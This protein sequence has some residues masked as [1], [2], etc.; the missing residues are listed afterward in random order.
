MASSK[1]IFVGMADARED[2]GLHLALPPAHCDLPP[3]GECQLAAKNGFMRHHVLSVR[4]FALD[5]HTAKVCHSG[6]QTAL[7]V[8]E[9]AI[10]LRTGL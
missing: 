4:W 8:K 9:Q 1:A 6:P 7:S 2:E 10:T 5:E 3:L